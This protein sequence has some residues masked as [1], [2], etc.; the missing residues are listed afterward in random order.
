MYEPEGSVFN[1][2]QALGMQNWK[3][4]IW[5][6]LKSSQSGKNYLIMPYIRL[7]MNHLLFF[8]FSWESYEAEFIRISVFV[9]HKPVA[10]FM[11]FHYQNQKPNFEQS[12]QRKD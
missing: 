4:K 11:H 9:G 3:P 10:Y 12:Y 1:F 5:F 2:F 6:L 7:E 8:P